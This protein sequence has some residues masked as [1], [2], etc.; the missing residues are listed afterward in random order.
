[1]NRANVGT[2][3]QMARGLRHAVER[4]IARKIAEGRK[5]EDGERI[6]FAYRTTLFTVRRGR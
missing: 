5:E 6:H 2:L 4:R 1:M 3:R